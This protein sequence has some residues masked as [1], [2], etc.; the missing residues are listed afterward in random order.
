[1]IAKELVSHELTPIS[2]SD[3]G[4]DAIALMSIFHVRHLPVIE[5][6]EYLG[7]ISE[8][9][10]YNHDMDAKVGTFHYVFPR[11]F[12]FEN[13]HI[14]EVMGIMAN[15]NLSIIPVLDAK[16]KFIGVITQDDL[17]SYYAKTFSFSEPGSILVLETSKAN[18]S[19]AEI[20]RIVES[21]NAAIISTFLSTSA[22]HNSV[23]VTLKIN[24]KD[25]NSI[26]ASFV[27]FDYHIKATFSE[28]EYVDALKD[29]YDLL[30]TYLNV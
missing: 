8:D 29:R 9:D 19:L 16:E 1:M 12:A 18:Y 14:F 21:E 27:R 26:I 11:L 22:D 5:N 7:L 13:F 28:L 25:I 15:H 17:I 10:I 24:K 6:G 30:M 2:K 23:E 20:S 3:S 4:E